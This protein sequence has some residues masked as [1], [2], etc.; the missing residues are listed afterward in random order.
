MFA[1][2]QHPARWA[3]QDWPDRAGAPTVREKLNNIKI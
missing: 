2:E 3:L 1:S